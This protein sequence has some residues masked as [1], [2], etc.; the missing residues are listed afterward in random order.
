VS[1]SL[2]IGPDDVRA[3][4]AR[5]AGVAHRTPVL[6]SRALDE[7]AGAEVLLKGEHLQRAGAFKFR[8]AYNRLSA[9][10]PEE[11]EAG[12]VAI[13]SGNHA[14]AVALAARLVGTRA[15][16]LMP[17]DAP[18]SKRAATEGYGAEVLGFDRYRDDREERVA[19][20]A[21]ERGATVIPAYD[22]PLVMAG[23][24]TTA[25]ELFE[26]AGDLDVLVVCAGGGGLLSGCATVAAARSPRPRVIGVQPEAAPNIARA[27]RTGRPAPVPVGR[28][29][30]D[31][32]QL[33]APGRLTWP[34]VEALVDD[35]VCVSDAEIVAAMRLLLERLKAVVEPSGASALAAVLAGR[36]ELP[37]GARVGVTL[38]GGNVDAARL[39]ALLG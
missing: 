33:A 14:Q 38:S 18:A 12:V 29:I 23:A 3:A 37:A 4:G 31:G 25:L 2:P 8:G 19:A 5:L 16:I 28:T 24:G 27:F 30:A 36:V 17:Q 26:Q 22:D 13:S 6:T 32:Q 7:L 20:L 15:A 11:R 35:V 10:T 21:A 1:V 34:V 9:L 39:A